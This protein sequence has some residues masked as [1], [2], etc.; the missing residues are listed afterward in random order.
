MT[1]TRSSLFLLVVVAAG[2]GCKRKPEARALAKDDGRLAQKDCELP[3]AG[4]VASD[5]VIKAGCLVSVGQK[6]VITKGSTL[7][8]EAGAK[9]SFKKGFGLEVQD[10]ALVAKGTSLQPVVFTSAETAPSAGDWS[11]IVL[12][13]ATKGSSIEHAVIEFA[14]TA[15]K[16]ALHVGKGAAKLALAGTTIRSS[17]RAGLTADNDDPFA[18]FSDNTFNKNGALAMDVPASALGSVTSIAADEPVRVRGRVTTSQTWPTV[19]SGIVVGSLFVGSA[20]PLPVLT[21]A[22]DTVL[23][24]EKRASIAI[25]D[26]RDSGALVATRVRFTSA[27]A[28]PSPGDWAGLRFGDRSPGTALDGCTIEFAGHDHAVP[29]KGS[30]KKSPPALTV[31]EHMKD[32]KV[33]QTTFRNNAGPGMGLSDLM[34]LAMLGTGGCAGLDAPSNRNKSVGQPLCEYHEDPFASIGLLG[35]ISGDSAP[36]LLDAPSSYG[37]II[38]NQAGAG[39]PGTTGAGTG[40]GGGGGT[41]GGLG[42][43]GHGSAGSAPGTGT[44]ATKLSGAKTKVSE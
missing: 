17:L 14:G 19:T 42:G 18:R 23:R 5:A 36:W 9:L 21:L 26:L 3:A 4:V 7:T 11:G 20:G 12:S 15:E 16:G 38:G 25:G 8:I 24:V 35:A 10:G 27:E 22:A 41:I 43:L 1:L 6:Y 33:V 29:P 39:G 34:G 40:G 13:S 37:G 32:F 30:K 2:L 28:K 44:A 31:V